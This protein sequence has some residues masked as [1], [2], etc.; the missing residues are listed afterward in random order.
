STWRPYSV[1]RV[2]AFGHPS[3]TVSTADGTS[4]LQV[5]T[6]CKATGATECMFSVDRQKAKIHIEDRG[7]FSDRLMEW[8]NGNGLLTAL[9]LTSTVCYTSRTPV[10]P[11]ERIIA[12]AGKTAARPSS[13]FSSSVYRAR[14]PRTASR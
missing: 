3:Y 12:T 1:R 13:N 7:S 4:T 10:G 5:P 14:R 6:G 9:S 11:N 8:T 2:S